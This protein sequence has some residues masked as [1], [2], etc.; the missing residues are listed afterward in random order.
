MQKKAQKSNGARG[1]SKK[2]TG[3]GKDFFL[4]NLVKEKCFSFFFSRERGTDANRE[5][6]DIFSFA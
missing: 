5:T 1:R 3:V 2:K 4:H 6:N